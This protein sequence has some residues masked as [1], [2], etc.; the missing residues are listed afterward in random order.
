MTGDDGIERDEESRSEAPGDGPTGGQNDGDDV[1]PAID[2]N[3]FVLSLSTSALAHMGECEGMPCDDVEVSLVHAKQTIDVLGLLELKTRGNLTGEDER[4]LTQVLYD[5][6][7]R[8]VA[9]SGN[10]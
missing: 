4:L 5:L 9:K 8:Y 3:T 10:R 2:F 7:M 1:V 6:R